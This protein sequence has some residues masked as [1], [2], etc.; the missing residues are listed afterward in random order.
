M[1][2]DDSAGEAAPPFGDGRRGV[3]SGESAASGAAGKTDGA[4]DIVVGGETG[5]SG[6]VAGAAEMWSSEWCEE[7]D[8]INA[9]SMKVADINSGTETE[10]AMNGICRAS[11]PGF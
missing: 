1:G 10:K 11:F 3:M 9:V 8:T 7:A 2:R 4:A 6:R 5:G